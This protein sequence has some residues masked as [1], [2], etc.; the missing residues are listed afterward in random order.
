MKARTPLRHAKILPALALLCFAT[1]APCADLFTK[2]TP[3]ETSI[4]AALGTDTT[5]GGYA[6]YP[7]AGTWRFYKSAAD[8]SSARGEATA[9]QLGWISLFDLA[10]A[11]TTAYV[12]M[13]M[14]VNLTGGGV[15]DYWTGRPCAGKK[16]SR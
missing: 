6:I 4:G 2:G 3:V 13:D 8:A 7:G 15:N 16:C 12:G 9:V 5:A 11:R 14:T 1:T 10:D